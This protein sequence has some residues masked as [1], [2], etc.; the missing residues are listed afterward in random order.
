MKIQNDGKVWLD[1]GECIP[2]LCPK[3]KW[4]IEYDKEVVMVRCIHCGYVGDTEEFSSNYIET[5]LK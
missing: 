3:C 4:P 5:P 1:K 2:F